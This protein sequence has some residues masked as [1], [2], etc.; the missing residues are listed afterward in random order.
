MNT[1]N[2]YKCD[3]GFVM[4]C[5]HVILLSLK[6]ECPTCHKWLIHDWQLSMDMLEEKLS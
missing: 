6:I 4:D 3:C 5:Q 1:Y 2:I